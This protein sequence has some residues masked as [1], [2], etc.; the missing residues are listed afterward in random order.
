M[1]QSV[2][3]AVL[4]CMHGACSGRAPEYLRLNPRVI[5]I[6]K[7][8]MAAKKP[9]AC[10]CHG[11]QLLAAAGGRLAARACACRGLVAV[12][13]LCGSFRPFLGGP[14]LYAASLNDPM[15]RVRT[16]PWQAA[17][18]AAPAPPTRPADPR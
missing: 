1:V 15:P 8:F 18:A 11:A 13:L 12:V 2:L 4:P 7:H 10:I 14:R 6:V 16:L 17:S 9:V 5:E 3:P